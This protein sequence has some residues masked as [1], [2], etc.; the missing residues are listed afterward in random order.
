MKVRTAL[1]VLFFAALPLAAYQPSSTSPYT[2][3]GT[4]SCSS[5]EIFSHEKVGDGFHHDSGCIQSGSPLYFCD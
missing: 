1:L 2:F 3:N 4:Y 5:C